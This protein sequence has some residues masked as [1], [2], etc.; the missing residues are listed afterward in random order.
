MH[1]LELDFETW[2]VLT[3]KGKLNGLGRFSTVAQY[4]RN[5]CIALM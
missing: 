2:Q 4:E 5:I 1:G 3:V